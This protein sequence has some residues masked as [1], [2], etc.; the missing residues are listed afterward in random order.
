MAAYLKAT[1]AGLLGAVIAPILWTLVR[2]GFG[3]AVTE[4]QFA[5]Q[6]EGS[7]GIGAVSVGFFEV[8]IALAML[9]GFVLAFVVVLRRSRRARTARG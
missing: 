9:V 8:D 7:A 2:V 4:L 6:P 3:L 5:G 1:L